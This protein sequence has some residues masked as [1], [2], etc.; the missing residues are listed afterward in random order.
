[1]LKRVQPT[2]EVAD[3]PAPLAQRFVVGAVDDAAEREADDISRAIVGSLR[4]HPMSSPGRDAT[5]IRRRTGDAVVRRKPMPKLVNGRVRWYDDADPMQTLYDTEEEA[6][7]AGAAFRFTGMGSDLTLPD[8]SGLSL[9]DP[10]VSTWEPTSSPPPV[11]T[12]GR[13]TG[14]SDGLL[15][16]FD[17]RSSGT[18]S[19]ESTGTGSVSPTVAYLEEFTD[20]GPLAQVV[21]TICGS[22][23]AL[24]SQVM[25]HL[26][27][28][29][30]SLDCAFLV[31]DMIVGKASGAAIDAL[32]DALADA[33]DELTDLVPV[34]RRLVRICSPALVAELVDMGATAPQCAMFADTCDASTLTRFVQLR[35]NRPELALLTASGLGGPGMTRLASYER[36]Q[37]VTLLQ[38]CSPPALQAAMAHGFAVRDLD[39]LLLGMLGADFVALVQVA[40]L[41]A[42]HLLAIADFG[43]AN[44]AR[45]RVLASPAQ[46]IELVT[47]HFA[48]TSARQRILGMLTMDETFTCLAGEIGTGGLMRNLLGATSGAEITVPLGA[49]GQAI[50]ALLLSEHLK[51]AEILLVHTH[52]ARVS[53]PEI[54]AA[55]AGLKDVQR[56]KRLVV[57]STPHACLADLI[58]F[59]PHV[60]ETWSYG[61]A[62]TGR[63][64]GLVSTCIAGSKVRAGF[65]KL[66]I[67]RLPVGDLLA[68]CAQPAFAKC[69]ALMVAT[70][71]DGAL[72]SANIATLTVARYIRLLDADWDSENI[73]LLVQAFLLGNAGRGLDQWIEIA[74]HA[75]NRPAQTIELCTVANW[76]A[77]NIGPLLAAYADN[78]NGLSVANWVTIAGLVPVDDH[79]AA[80]AFAQLRDWTWAG[81][82]PFVRAFHANPNRLSADDWIQFT[83]LCGGDAQAEIVPFAQLADW[84]FNLIY[85]LLTAYVSDNP[86][87]FTAPQW[88]TIAEREDRPNAEH[89]IE[90]A[91]GD[92][93]RDIILTREARF[94]E[95]FPGAIRIGSPGWQG[96]VN[97]AIGNGLTSVVTAADTDPRPVGNSA[98]WP[99]ADRMSHWTQGGNTTKTAFVAHVNNVSFFV[100][101]GNH[102]GPNTYNITWYADGADPGPYKENQVTI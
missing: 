50:Y 20:A 31:R 13:G 84:S 24:A 95:L 63:Q 97:Q 29:V 34:V 101:F 102:A 57:M 52:L 90:V 53:M 32:L 59:G 93:G 14:G 98:R 1:M 21:L 68:L 94:Q 60:V 88:V 86:N 80:V 8:G 66:L 58:E 30:R 72:V 37:V 17:I 55:I 35:L 83:Y 79:V 73:N 77:S 15:P 39:R 25:G 3:A 33:G 7:A 76:S 54:K 28:A 48:T 61:G 18:R 22:D 78:A 99:R 9:D 23:V 12:P 5:R 44:V 27:P 75:S 69:A 81:I 38:I 74:T 85:Q 51:P 42:P 56:W 4:D 82:E 71:M 41:T 10:I 87:G 40:Q 92:E 100:A 6:A 47:V 2:S 91:R 65:G 49:L 36:R 46:M 62:I 64:I 43:Q 11:R 19:G 26:T 96:L 89:A 70:P 16:I 45:L 67:S